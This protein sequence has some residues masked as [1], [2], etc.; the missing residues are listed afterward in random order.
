M[1]DEKV[2]LPRIQLLHPKIRPL[3]VKAIEDAEKQ[4]NITIR[5][6]QGLRTF[7]EQDALFNQPKD[8]KDNDGDGKIDEADEKVTNAKGGQSI[9]NYGLAFDIAVMSAD[10]KNINWIYDTAKIAKII[11]AHGFVWGGDWVSI[12]D[13]PHFEMTFK[14]TWQTLKALVD[15]KQ[16]YANGYVII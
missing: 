4:L 3:V 14:H 2:S 13:K 12:V 6:T 8:G 9:H 7:K 15:K 1:K 11:K 10:G 16:V 5:V